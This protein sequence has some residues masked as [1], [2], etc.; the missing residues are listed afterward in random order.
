M[1]DYGIEVATV[2]DVSVTASST[3]VLDVFTT[4]ATTLVN[5]VGAGAALDVLDVIPNVLSVAVT[6]AFAGEPTPRT[7]PPTRHGRATAW[8]RD[9]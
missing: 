1:T 8:P 9:E 7:T 6:S 3:A 2:A 4:E 5:G